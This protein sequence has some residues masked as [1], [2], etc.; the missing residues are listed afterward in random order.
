MHPR[1]CITFGYAFCTNL[2]IFFSYTVSRICFPIRIKSI[3]F[4]LVRQNYF[5]PLFWCPMKMFF[6]KCNFSVVL[7]S[8][9]HSFKRQCIVQIL[10][11][12]SKSELISEWIVTAVLNLSVR[13]VYGSFDQFWHHFL[14]LNFTRNI[15]CGSKTF[16]VLHGLKTGDYRYCKLWRNLVIKFPTFSQKLHFCCFDISSFTHIN[17]LYIAPNYMNYSI[18]TDTDNLFFRVVRYA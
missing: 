13:R 2:Y 4:W 15:I 8:L 9:N 1:T 16:D 17:V 5:R 12:L 6:G 3:K 7:D 18:E 10:T 11:F 14:L